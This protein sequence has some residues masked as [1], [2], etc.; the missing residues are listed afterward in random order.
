MREPSYRRVGNPEGLEGL[1]IAGENSPYRALASN[2]QSLC[3]SD[4]ANAERGHLSECAP[5]ANSDCYAPLTNDV[6]NSQHDWNRNAGLDASGNLD[7]HLHQSRYQPWRAARVFYGGGLAANRNSYRQVGVGV[8]NRCSLT[9]HAPRCGLPLPRDI[10]RNDIADLSGSR[11]GI[12]C[13]A[14]LVDGSRWPLATG[15][16]REDA[17]S[18]RRDGYREHLACL[19]LVGDGHLRGG[20]G[21]PVGHNGGGLR[22]PRVDHG[23]GHPVERHADAGQLCAI[24]AVAARDGLQELP[25]A[26]ADTVEHHDLTG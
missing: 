2:A 23:S 5:L 10:E 25:G 19:A 1:P 17:G 18:R 3:D 20:P 22:G 26:D 11:G 8:R 21:N 12:D 24:R 6:A 9:I 4:A 7:V 16:V 14:V 15:I 13:D